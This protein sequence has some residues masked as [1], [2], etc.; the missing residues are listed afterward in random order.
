MNTRQAIKTK[1][2][3]RAT[4]GANESSPLDTIVGANASAPPSH[5]KR[6]P[7]LSCI[8]TC[9]LRLSQQCIVL[10]EKNVSL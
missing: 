5:L 9:E 8:L 10:I 2:P 6:L 1:T 7:E 3:T 4:K